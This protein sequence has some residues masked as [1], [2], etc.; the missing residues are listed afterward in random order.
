MNKN[1]KSSPQHRFISGLLTAVLIAITSVGCNSKSLSGGDYSGPANNNGTATFDDGSSGAVNGVTTHA[2]LFQENSETGRPFW[3][4]AGVD[5]AIGI[6]SSVVLKDASTAALPTGATLDLAA[7]LIRITANDVAL[8]GYDFSNGAGLDG[9]SIGAVSGT[10]ITNCKFVGGVPVR[11]DVG[12]SHSYF[13]YNDVDGGGGA[14]NTAVGALL[15]FRGSVSVEYNWIRNAPRATLLLDGGG[16]LLYRNNVLE[17]AGF[18]PATDGSFLKLLGGNFVKA[19]IAFNTVI[20]HAGVAGG[21]LLQMHLNA[22]GDL[23]D[24]EVSYNSVLSLGDGAHRSSALIFH[25]GADSQY[26][27]SVTGW[28][29]DNYVDAS[30]AGGIAPTGMSGFVYTRN[31]DLKTGAAL[32]TP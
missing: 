20:Q 24:S 1:M 11:S 9:I 6:A 4:V 22:S 32:V 7:R 19:K 16:T 25:M 21:E 23:L 31:I 18:A 27:W 12:S 14:G 10:R 2:A 8:D 15:S 29:H 26:P 30:G 3:K 28:A 5:Y 13:G 17:D